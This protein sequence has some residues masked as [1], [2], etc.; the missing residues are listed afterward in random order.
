MDIFEKLTILADAAKYDV[1]CSSSGSRRK[2]IDNQLGNAA[3]S[4]ICHTYT[5][6]GRC[7][8]LLKILFTNF[9]VYDCSYCVNRVSN[10]I[11]RAAFT[12]GEL[13]D[14][15]IN[16]YRR[17]YIEG[18]FISSG[19]LRNPDDTMEQL[20]RVMRD[21][22]RHHGFNGYIHLKCLPG[23]SERLIQEA[24]S[25]ADRLSINIEIPSESNLQLLAPDKS[26]SAI[27]RPMEV[28]R[29]GI[30]ENRSER[31]KFS[32]APKFTPAGQSTQL[33]VGA[34]PE[35]DY[36]ILGLA[37]DL[38]RDKGLKRVYYSAY[39]PVNRSDSRLPALIE[40]PLVREN[41]LYQADWLLR[42]YGFS[43]E[44]ILSPAYPELDLKIDPKLAYAIRN[45]ELFPVNIN[46][47]DYELLLRV[48]GIG[49]QSARRI[50][51]AR[52]HGKIRYEHLKKIGVVLKRARH[53]ITCPGQ[54]TCAE[55]ALSTSLVQTEKR[56]KRNKQ[57]CMLSFSSKTTFF[58]DGTFE[59][60]LTAVFETF[61]RKIA[62]DSIRGNESAE[63]MNLFERG[64][65]IETSSEKAE[66]VWRKL[67]QSLGEKKRYR[68]YQAFLSG[69]ENIEMSIYNYIKRAVDQR[70]Q[71]TVQLDSVLQIEKMSRKVGRE[72]HRM[73]GF[74]RFR[75][76]KDSLYLAFIA[77]QYDVL[78]L[79]RGHFQRRYA[80]QRWMIYDSLRHYGLYYDTKQTQEIRL[81]T[82]SLEMDKLLNTDELDYQKLWKEYFQHINI[83]ERRNPKLH[84]QK[85]PR[86]Y[87]EYLT[88]KQ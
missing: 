10:D 2:N 52:R 12:P 62:P 21:L 59:G 61:S 26:Y 87:W 3:P 14:L 44:D 31:K 81:Q 60:L 13:V 4:G 5:E 64:V 34:S 25:Y 17:N 11:P 48:P 27:Y 82:E 75:K 8:S 22:R 40:P 88:E 56:Q 77:P 70:V 68:L 84:L 1:S 32:S 45:P 9:C 58:Y 23:V 24:G 67:K 28:I 37:K 78:S 16:F 50:I 29:E 47:V 39:V 53:F 20:I 71:D 36:E 74:V 83:P 33:I 30:S 73:R 79:I 69:A 54:P 35:S 76:L 7:V 41:R 65:E 18:L 55:L 46:A 49:L 80:D 19:V 57:R 6:D 42:L 63:Q 15:T 66:R 51:R 85:L 86:R 72:A 43:L 38:Y